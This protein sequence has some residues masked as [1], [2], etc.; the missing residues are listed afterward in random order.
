LA[1][2]ELSRGFTSLVPKPSGNRCMT[3]DPLFKKPSAQSFTHSINLQE[4]LDIL[5]HEGLLEAP[6]EDQNESCTYTLSFHPVPWPPQCSAHLLTNSWGYNALLHS[7]SGLRH[8]KVAVLIA[9]STISST[10][11]GTSHGPSSSYVL[12]LF[13][14]PTS[15]R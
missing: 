4:L 11:T 9:N 14:T 6:V 12:L 7:V 10:I 2:Y 15:D 13:G 1:K 5:R 3:A 8:L